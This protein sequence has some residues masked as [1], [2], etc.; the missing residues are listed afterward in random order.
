M[1]TWPDFAAPAMYDNPDPRWTDPMLPN[2]R[3]IWQVARTHGYAVGLHGSMKR[4]VDLIAVPWSHPAASPDEL[5]DAICDAINAR[6]AT[7]VERK[8]HGRLALNLQVDGWVKLID[9]SIVPPT[10]TP[11]T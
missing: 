9:L 3:R 5:I 11:G 6:R 8:P 2:F 1:G 10:E 7:L 4:D